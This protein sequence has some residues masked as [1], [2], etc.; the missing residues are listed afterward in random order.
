[1]ILLFML[2]LAL[3]FSLPLLLVFYRTKPPTTQRGAAMALY[4]AQLAALPTSTASYEGAR[5]ELERRLLA[6][7][8]LAP[9]PT[10]GSAKLL[11]VLTMI[12]LP[13]G[14]FVLYI[15]GSTP[16]VPSE[17][18]ARVVAEQMLE[19][20]KLGQLIALLRQH[21]T[22]VPPDSANASQGQAYLA[23][24]LTEQAGHIT[25]E[26]LALFQNALAHA[27]LNAN[28][29]PLVQQ[30]LMQAGTAESGHN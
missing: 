9:E 22:Q 24:A 28:W 1:M 11:L 30:R 10:G 26:A 17:P 6:A 8:K 29:R 21:L 3:A 18:H 25:P 19:Q 27:P 15:P 7:D 16:F 5:L 4:R 14:G 20:Q 23:E 13:I 2:L 12:L